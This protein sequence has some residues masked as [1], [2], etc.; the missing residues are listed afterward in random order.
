MLNDFGLAADHLTV[1]AL[2]A[3][4][5]PGSTHINVVNALSRE[6]PRRRMSSW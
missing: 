5:A 3:P 4:H 1:A 6:R 2:Q